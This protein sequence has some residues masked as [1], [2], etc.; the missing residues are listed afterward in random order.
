MAGTGVIEVPRPALSGTIPSV[1]GKDGLRFEMNQLLSYDDDSLIEEIRRV[2]AL[3]PGARLTRKT[4]D[5]LSRASSSTIVHRLGGWE[6]ALERAG[7]GD[8]YGG[9]RVTDKMRRQQGRLLTAEEILVELRRLAD[10]KGQP[11]MTVDDVKRSDLLSIRVVTSRFGTW[12]A[13]IEAAGLQLSSLGRRWTDEDYYENLLTVWTHYQRAPNY[14]EMDKPPSRITS[15]AYEAKFGTWGRAK[16]AFVDRVNSDI[17]IPQS[18]PPRIIAPAASPILVA[19]DQRSIPL[20]LRYKIL[21]RDR[22]RCVICGRSPATELTCQ[23]HIDHIVAVSRGG[24]SSE[25]N[26]R[27]SCADCNIGKG[28]GD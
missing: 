4:F 25:E 18:E 8:R 24:T 1:P 23:L 27:T 26:L 20:G 7:L 17:E 10:E 22:F 2:A 19:E 15:G 3:L 16:Q 13:A 12:R 11:T 6:S 28:A 14:G 9:R 21:R 5:G